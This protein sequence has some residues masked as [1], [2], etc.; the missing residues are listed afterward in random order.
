MSLGKIKR[1]LQSDYLAFF[2]RE[3][4]FDIYDEGIVFE[5]GRPF[6]A[7][8]PLRGM[9]AYRRAL[10]ALRALSQRTM[11][12]GTVRCMISSGEEY[13]HDL[14]VAW[15]C[16]GTITISRLYLY[17]PIYISA[18]SLYKVA[19]RSSP[20]P[21]DTWLSHPIKQHSLEFTEMYPPSIRSIMQ[22]LWWQR[23]EHLQP[24]L[25]LGVAASQSPMHFGEPREPSLLL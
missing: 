11:T 22:T 17:Q 5:L 3:P 8:T 25:A 20:A 1:T 24:V 18:I 10:R 4:N 9:P 23:Q 15:T 2:E 12:D 6:H 19:P 14:K 13:G 16:E 21:R 7:A